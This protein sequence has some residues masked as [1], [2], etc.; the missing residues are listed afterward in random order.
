M[1][2]ISQTIEAASLYSFG[3]KCA[4]GHITYFD[5]RCVCPG[6]RN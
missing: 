2:Q 4:N 1:T 6:D 5:K 3:V